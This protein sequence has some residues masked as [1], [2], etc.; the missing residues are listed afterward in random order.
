MAK[1]GSKKTTSPPFLSGDLK[2]KVL[3]V[4][5]CLGG[6]D[7]AYYVLD[8]VKLGGERASIKFQMKVLVK[9]SNRELATRHVISALETKKIIT[10][11]DGN[12]L[13]IP[14]DPADASAGEKIRLDIKPTGSGSGGG[15]DETAKNESTQAL[16]CALR[17]SRSQDLTN[18]NWSISDLETV[19]PNCDI[20]PT[21]TW[22]NSLETLLMVDPS[23]YD[24]HIKGA[25]LIYNEVKK[26]NS[27]KTYTFHRGSDVVSDIED[28]FYLCNK[29]ITEG[30][31]FADIN[32]WS[33]ADI[34]LVSNEFISTHL[35][36]LKEYTTI[37][38]LNQRIEE[39]FDSGDLVGVSLKKIETG[40]GSWSVKNHKDLPKDVSQVKFR[41]LSGT[42]SSID[43]YLKWGTADK[44]KIQFRDTTGNGEG[45]QGEIKGLS[46][47]Q[48]K[49]GGGVVDGYLK[50]L[51]SKEVGVGTVAKHKT[52]KDNSNPNHTNKKTRLDFTNE[53]FNLTK[54]HKPATLMTGF[55]DDDQ[56]LSN[57]ARESKSWR[58]SKYIN[59]KLVDIIQNLND[60]QKTEL[61]R[62]WYFYA[63]SQSEL[64]A[65]Y[66][67]VM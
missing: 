36:K 58:Y 24:S 33:P 22:G 19:L 61:V 45:W 50:K 55:E 1:R 60:D 65:V 59:L 64:S 57:I 29:N 62:A 43:L 51:Y 18:D 42:F 28:T 37:E 32:K 27:S 44:D 48:G 11:R 23:W 4:M 12:R 6:D 8:N 13:E 34:Y 46:A 20:N 5:D 40:N 63:A 52:I 47:A 41:G 66:A 3:N 35:T 9:K 10:N 39:L 54:K 17:W 25:N 26:L 7:F 67:K 38:L 56:T 16:F 21:S 49:I 2:T 14:L 31:K 15:S 30:T 53:I